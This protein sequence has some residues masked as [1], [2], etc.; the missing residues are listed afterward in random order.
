MIGPDDENPQLPNIVYFHGGYQEKPFECTD[1]ISAVMGCTYTLPGTWCDL[2]R[3]LEAGAEYI[4]FHAAYVKSENRSIKEFSEA[5]FTLAERM[6]N[7]TKLTIGVVIKRDT[8]ASVIEELKRSKVSGILLDIHD[9]SMEEICTATT[10]LISDKPYW[11]E[12]IISQLPNSNRR[13]PHGTYFRDDHSTSIKCSSENSEYLG[14]T[15]SCTRTWQELTQELESGTSL[16]AI[17]VETLERLYNRSARNFVDATNA[18]AKFIP[19][20]PGVIISVVI[21]PST[22]QSIILDLKKIDQIVGISLDL[23][24]WSFEECTPGVTALINGNSYWPEDIISQLPVSIKKPI[25]IYF[26]SDWRTYIT[27]EM[28][29]QFNENTPW[30]WVYSANWGDLSD[31]L[32]KNP[33]QIAFHVDML[34]TL[35]VNIT[36]LVSMLQKLIRVA[37]PDADIA[38]GI[39]FEP[40]TTREQIEEFRR[41]GGLAAIPSA[42]VYGLDATYTAIQSLTDKIPYFPEDIISQL[43]NPVK[44][45]LHVYF[46]SWP[47]YATDEIMYRTNVD[48]PWD[49]AYCSNWTHLS[50]VIKM[51]PHQIAFHV[52]VLD[53]LDVGMTEL[54]SMLDKLIKVTGSRS[55]IAIGMVFEPNTP[56]ELI[57][58][59]QRAGG[60]AAIPSAAKYGIDRN[61][62][63]IRSMTDRIPYFPEDIINQ[64]PVGKPRYIHFREHIDSK[65]AI[66]P[67]TLEIFKKVLPVELICVAG[68]DKLDGALAT[69][70]MGLVFNIENV[71]SNPNLTLQDI[72]LMIRTKLKILNLNIPILVAVNKD[73]PVSYIAQLKKEGVQGI[74]PVN[75]F[76][77][78]EVV[79][80]IQA[81]LEGES[82]WPKHIIDQLPRPVKKKKHKVGTMILTSRQAQILTYIKD[83][84]ASNKVIA[85]ALNLSESTVKLHVGSILKKY[86]MKNRTQ[87]ALFDNKKTNA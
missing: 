34:D 32:K 28:L 40:Y 59:L 56:V 52:N 46:H 57:R 26:R 69:N 81:S 25:H 77:T 53:T 78:D 80:A 84:G 19:G 67:K 45:P 63:A 66:P 16:I 15:W 51:Y 21:T 49:Y 20:H 64:L 31:I 23:N 14:V 39:G 33:T 35:N 3:E 36:E 42:A 12:H 6:P 55:D 54:V 38:I 83:R 86:G 5:I 60:I 50:E 11:P 17:H 82:Y 4:A 68:W 41:A 58:D 18:I 30:E 9:Y 10:A 7:F 48:T 24:F 62:D 43:P 22:S 1:A 75:L 76:G 65:R 85:K 13:L 47:T 72:I 71:V 27:D 29:R 87:L 37:S 70:P 44:K 61:Y 2:T 73:T 79:D 8:D 74:V